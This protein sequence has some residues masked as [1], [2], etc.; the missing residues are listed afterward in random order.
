MLKRD[1]A[2]R[3][4]DDASLPLTKE[5]LERQGLTG[6]HGR[7]SP[8]AEDE[9]TTTDPYTSKRQRISEMRERKIASNLHSSQAIK[10]RREAHW[11]SE[12]SSLHYSAG[13][14]CSHSHAHH[15]VHKE[16]G[17][18]AQD[19][20]RYLE[21]DTEHDR[22]A[23]AHAKA[24]IEI[25]KAV[26]EGRLDPKIYRGMHAYPSYIEKSEDDL[27]LQKFSG[28][29]G[30]LRAPAHIRSTCRVDYNPEMCKDYKETGFCGFGDSCVF[31]HDR[32][33]Y[34]PGWML[35]MEFEKE[36]QRKMER[37]ARGQ[38]EAEEEE[39]FEVTS[40]EDELDENGFPSKCAICE[41]EFREPVQTRCGHYFCESCALRH[42]GKKS[43]CFTC[44]KTTNGIFN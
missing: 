31:I 42:Y 20:A 13:H 43:T 19:G 29:L 26:K 4:E 2:D 23:L 34:K 10:Q 6:E 38:G 12:I 22:D 17:E 14:N 16:D 11:K 18:T 37:L 24:N 15:D 3:F 33:D 39:N 30:P 9:T 36:Q 40:S 44:A 32:G 28:T 5:T 35:D 25:S 1:M 21:I 8:L 27:R 7:P 41:G